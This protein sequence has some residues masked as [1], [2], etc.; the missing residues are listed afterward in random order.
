MSIAWNAWAVV[1]EEVA[2][3]RAIV[4]A[5]LHTNWA[6]SLPSQR[7]ALFVVDHAGI[8]RSTT[9]QSYHYDQSVVWGPWGEVAGGRAPA[10][11]AI[12]TLPWGEWP[13]AVFMTDVDG[14]VVTT[15]G[16]PERGYPGG[17]ASVAQGRSVPGAPVTVVP[18]GDWPFALFITDE[19]GAV[20]TTA[21]NPQ[22]NFPGGWA[23][24]GDVR[25][26]PGSPVTIVNWGD[27]PFAAYVT[28]SDGRIM[29]SAGNPQMG[30][31]GGWAEVA[32]GLAQPGS[33]VTAVAY[34]DSQQ[35]VVVV[36]LDGRVYLTLGNPQDGYLPWRVLDG[37]K[38]P[39]GAS[40]SASLDTNLGTILYVTDVNGA[41][42]ANVS[43]VTPDAWLTWWKNGWFPVVMP[44]PIA[45]PGA[46]V[47]AVRGEDVLLTTNA[48]GTV[49]FTT[50]KM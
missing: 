5:T 19:N 36:G 23:M 6:A 35:F 20:Y 25:A 33:Q 39:L 43:G 11:A 50:V 44:Q 14:S 12:T 38:A 7:L 49:L 9:N 3:P 45:A 18:W 30:F 37:V 46:P 41:I 21:G 22:D 26:R 29:T 48:K 42:H 8:V 34:G 16:G 47:T 27:W 1:S 32:N 31:P 40:V 24:L 15:A 2:V 4:T 10:G 28:A 13:L 17:W